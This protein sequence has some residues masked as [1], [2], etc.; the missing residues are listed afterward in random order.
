MLQ[1]EVG[2]LT[3]SELVRQVRRKAEFVEVGA[4]LTL[5]RNVRRENPCTRFITFLAGK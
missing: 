4:P 3:K 5:K 2:Q 1:P